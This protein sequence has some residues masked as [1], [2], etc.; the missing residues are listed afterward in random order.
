LVLPA[1]ALAPVPAVT[2]LYA[3]WTLPIDIADPVAGKTAIGS[4]SLS[5]L[6]IYWPFFSPYKKLKLNLHCIYN[7]FNK[8]F[9]PLNSIYSPSCRK[10]LLNFSGS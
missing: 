5:G 9:L 3:C 6:S 1:V 2:L 7:I 4:V 10:I 8:Q